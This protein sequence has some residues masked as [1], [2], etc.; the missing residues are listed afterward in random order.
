MPQ[1]ELCKRF[2]RLQTVPQGGR[3]A[4]VHVHPP[5]R[6]ERDGRGH[7]PPTPDDAAE[8]HVGFVH[9]G[10][11]RGL[12]RARAAVPAAAAVQLQQLCLG[13]GHGRHDVLDLGQRA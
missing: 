3:S 10:H 6:V 12:G 13:R 1:L 8:R 9:A 4:D 2:S 11:G 5:D 7:H